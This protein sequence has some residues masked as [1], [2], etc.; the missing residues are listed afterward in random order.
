MLGC[1]VFTE[2]Y[3][4]ARKAVKILEG[5][6]YKC[7]IKRTTDTKLE[8]CGFVL[9]INGDCTAVSDIL[10]SSGISYKKLQNIRRYEE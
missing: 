3:T 8:G 4:H 5:Y 6:G 2:S 1:K 9:V 10:V 7:R